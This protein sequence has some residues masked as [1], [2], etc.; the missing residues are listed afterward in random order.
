LKRE[1]AGIV[2]KCLREYADFTDAIVPQ[3]KS[4]DLYF[5][6][7]ARSSNVV[8]MWL[9]SRGIKGG[10]AFNATNDL[11]RVFLEE[12]QA[13]SIPINEFGRKMSI[14]L[15]GDFSGKSTVRGFKLDRVVTFRIPEIRQSGDSQ[16]NDSTSIN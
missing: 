10:D 6:R 12:T 15:G 16:Q 13:K 4:T 14:C 11:Y 1:A 5:K 8:A 2:A 9:A 3:T 7:S